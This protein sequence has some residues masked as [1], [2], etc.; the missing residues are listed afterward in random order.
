MYGRVF[1]LIARINGVT[2]IP[3]WMLLQQ[4]QQEQQQMQQQE[5]RVL[6]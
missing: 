3:Q 5:V 4:Q 2:N 6:A 1:H